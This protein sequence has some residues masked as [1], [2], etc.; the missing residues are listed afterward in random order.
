MRSDLGT[1][2]AFALLLLLP[3][4]PVS[5][6]SGDLAAARMPHAE[7]GSE[8]WNLTARFD[9]GEYLMIELCITNIGLGDANAAVI[10]HLIE[11]DGTVHSFDGAKSRGEWTLSDDRLHMVIG[12]LELDQRGPVHRLHIWKERVRVDLAF[13]AAGEDTRLSAPES[14]DRGF[15]LLGTETAITGQLWTQGS[16]ERTVQGR[17]VRTHRWT[18]KIESSF[19]LRRIEL[20]TL[21]GDTSVYL[22]DTTDPSGGAE[23]W[24]RVQR[25]ERVLVA[26]RV[27]TRLVW[28]KEPAPEGF[29][30]PE[31][32]EIEGN[33]VRG[34]FELGLDLVR[35]D[36]LRELPAAV[37]WVLAPFIRWR[38]AW[39]AAPFELEIATAA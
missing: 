16:E 6:A 27:S 29:P 20:F 2:A 39:S 13:E 11:A 33:G 23:S 38:T 9:T 32:I 36:P 4:T 19:V 10:G 8:F 1:A 28:T 22:V 15:D 5:A 12:K 14:R 34:R 25:D 18:E 26:E 30:L 3:A 7:L 21:D 31:S 17:L 24:L 35:Y 37:R